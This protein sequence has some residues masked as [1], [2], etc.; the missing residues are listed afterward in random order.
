MSLKLAL[1]DELRQKVPHLGW[2]V[3]ASAVRDSLGSGDDDPWDAGRCEKEFKS[4]G[5]LAMRA[6]RVE[7]LKSAYDHIS[8]ALEH[9]SAPFCASYAQQLANSVKIADLRPVSLP[10]APSSVVSATIDSLKRNDGEAAEGT[11]FTQQAIQEGELQKQLLLQ[12]RTAEE[13]LKL[14]TRASDL[15]KQLQ[16]SK[17]RQDRV[18]AQ[19]V[20]AVA[21]VTAASFADAG[22]I[23]PELGAEGAGEYKTVEMIAQQQPSFTGA[24][25]ASAAG[26]LRPIEVSGLEPGAPAA[27]SVSK[28]LDRRKSRTSEGVSD[29]EGKVKPRENAVEKEA[30]RT[31]STRESGRRPRR[32]GSNV[33]LE[34]LDDLLL[35]EETTP[36]PKQSLIATDLGAVAPP[37]PSRD[38]ERPETNESDRQRIST[39]TRKRAFDH[40]SSEAAEN[41]PAT[42]AVVSPPLKRSKSD[43]PFTAAS[44]PP[45]TSSSSLSDDSAEVVPT[46]ASVSAM[47]PVYEAMYE[48]LRFFLSHSTAGMFRMD[49][50]DESIPGYSELVKVPINIYDIVGRVPGA[51][52]RLSS[53]AKL[54]E[55]KIPPLSHLSSS[56]KYT[57]AGEMWRDLLQMFTNALVFNASDSSYYRNALTC[58]STV[59]EEMRAILALERRVMFHPPAKSPVEDASDP[60]QELDSRSSKPLIGK[61][62][63]DSPSDPLYPHL[64][65]KLAPEDQE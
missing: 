33:L 48:L 23:G 59:R 5:V 45:L 53:K 60:K 24:S 1:I 2:D 35:P 8:Y 40:I 54:G 21:A 20:A 47:Q 10:V 34:S 22:A 36:K 32:S 6:K 43:V 16:A 26:P 30:V 11:E 56:T 4:I 31:P 42:A 15:M 62:S 7:Y 63:T 46:L 49:V 9:T 44:P 52:D 38:G 65:M 28:K 13:N 64:Y 27:E 57:F 14:Q 17:Q 29:K 3:I 39:R 50:S 41:S 18:Q 58:L 37:P 12:Q 19:A 61:R 55:Y 25:I 51:L